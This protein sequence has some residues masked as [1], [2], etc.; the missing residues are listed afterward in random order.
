[1]Y[2]R[3]IR[4]NNFILVRLIHPTFFTPVPRCSSRL[5]VE[6]EGV[7]CVPRQGVYVEPQSFGFCKVIVFVDL[8][9]SN[10]L[11]I[12]RTSNNSSIRIE[13][14]VSRFAERNFFEYVGDFFNC[15]LFDFNV[16]FW[17][18]CY[19]SRHKGNYENHGYRY[20]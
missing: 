16:L 17:S 6:V 13:L 4:F 12:N 10:I 15:D 20:P 7:S 19:G 8:E 1:M 18:D 9:P 3:Y 14:S 11:R 5:L 2:L